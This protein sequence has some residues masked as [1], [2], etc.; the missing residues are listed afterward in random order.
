MTW[1][2]LVGGVAF[3]FLAGYAI[4]DL[5]ARRQLRRLDSEIGLARRRAQR[6]FP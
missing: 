5:V 6:R 4:A 1:M 3:G 2:D